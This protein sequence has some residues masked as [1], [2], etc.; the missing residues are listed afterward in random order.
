MIDAW[1]LTESLELRWL[2]FN[3]KEFRADLYQDAR[4]AFTARQLPPD[5]V[6]R[7][8]M[9][10]SS[11]TGR[12]RFMQKLY[13]DSIVVVRHFGR[14]ALFI[15]F[16]ANPEWE[17]ITR[18]L[19]TDAAG[20]PI[21]TWR[22]RPDLVARVFRMKSRALIR[23]IC[24]NGIFGRCVAHCYTVEYQKR[25]L[26]HIHLLVL[27]EKDAHFDTVKRI[28]QVIC[29]EIPDPT[30]GPYAERL[31]DIVTRVLIYCPCGAENPSS[32]CM[33]IRN[34]GLICSG[35]FPRAYQNETT[36]END[37]YPNYCRCAYGP[38]IRVKHPIWA[39]ETLLIGNERVVPY[40]PYLTTRT[41]GEVNLLLEISTR[42][43]PFQFLT[44][45][46]A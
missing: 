27:L 8:I 6:G 5:Q 38:Q 15:T 42:D 10:P 16:T 33:K 41:P 44:L 36:I 34:G 20:V 37:G 29:A 30:V 43:L 18:E 14:P 25:G 21:Q 2:R 39:G 22:D 1:A 19:L 3:Q 4:H 11:F 13:Q 32:P 28:D 26:P 7:R 40:N 9:L 12:D 24:H 23:E 35:G 46:P 45:S 17:E 31:Y